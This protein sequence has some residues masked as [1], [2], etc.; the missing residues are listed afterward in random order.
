VKKKFR[1][2]IPTA[3][4]GSRVNRISN[5]LNKSLI[6]INNKAAISHIID[7]FPLNYEFVIPLGFK[8]N[9]VKQYLEL[10]HPERKFFFVNIKKYYGKGSGLGLTLIKSKKYLQC[11]FIFISCDTLIKGKID[12]LPDHNWVG[13]AQGKLSNQYRKIEL[14]NNKNFKKFLSKKSK[15]KINCKNYIGL[16]GIYDF[17]E[18]WKNMENKKDIS[19]L[20]GEV[21]GINLIQKNNIKP[22]KFNWYDIG[23]EKS[24]YAAQKALRVDKENPNILEKKKECIWIND[25]L[26]I[27]YF[28]DEDVVNKRFIRSNYIKNFVPKILKKKKNMY[29]YSKFD[30]KVFSKIEDINKFKALLNHIKKFHKPIK[31]LKNNKKFFR[32][33]NKFYKN[34]TYKRLSIFYK[35]FKIKDNDYQINNSQKI[36]LYKLLKKINWAKISDGLAGR[37]HGDLHFENILYSKKKGKICF[38][39]WRHEFSGSLKVGDIYYDLAK[40][41]HGLFVSHDSITRNDYLIEIR[42]SK[43]RINI[44]NKK[45]YHNYIKMYYNWL[46]KNKYDIKKVNIL[47]GLIFLNICA[48]HHFPY[49]IFLYYMGK[50]ILIEEI[51]N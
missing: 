48:L 27:K 33:C 5:N 24:Y 4:T 35:K 16:A 49:S 12:Y 11:P 30:G 28:E 21:F 40:M 19:I 22:Y 6:P 15:K 51:E 18:F 14:D 47:T 46:K 44:K 38:L 7:Y 50:K 13:Y 9:L 39:D 1:V 34:K 23:N 41:L 31:K 2:C 17:K 43:V 20:Q 32:Q 25:D 36:T 29:S 10:A 8:G 45:I 3:G 26:V 37:F 42:K